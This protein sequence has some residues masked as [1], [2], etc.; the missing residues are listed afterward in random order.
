[1]KFSIKNIAILLVI[2][3]IIGGNIA[4][5]VRMSNRINGLEEINAVLSVQLDSCKTLVEQDS[6][7][8]E[9]ATKF[10]NETIG[11][12]ESP[13]QLLTLIFSGTLDESKSGEYGLNV[14][15]LKVYLESEEM[16]RRG[17]LV[18]DCTSSS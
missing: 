4:V 1:M 15:K 7:T 17:D 5:F 8:V 10:V 3:A 12:I 18:S 16:K 9:V 13:E 6:K 2:L 14:G 11:I